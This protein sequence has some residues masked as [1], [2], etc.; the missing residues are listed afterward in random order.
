M[1]TTCDTR[2]HKIIDKV[3][4]WSNV[5]MLVRLHVLR[6]GK[7]NIDQRVLHVYHSSKRAGHSKKAASNKSKANTTAVAT[8][9]SKRKASI[10]IDNNATKKKSRVI[11]RVIT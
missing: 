10:G 2:I 7:E 4:A 1:Y 9:Q 8:R 6:K 3:T 5:F 11:W